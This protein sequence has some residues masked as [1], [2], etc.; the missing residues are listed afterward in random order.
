MTPEDNERHIA[1]LRANSRDER[2]RIAVLSTKLG[3]LK[4]SLEPASSLLDDVDL[5]FLGHEVLSQ[6]R[7]PQALALW[8]SQADRMFKIAV[9]VRKNVEGLVKKF[10]PDARV[11]GG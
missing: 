6:P 3:D 1:S 11:I 8:L 4:Q 7:T 9:D 10:G 2:A 5:F